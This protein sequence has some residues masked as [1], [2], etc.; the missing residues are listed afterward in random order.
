[1]PDYSLSIDVILFYSFISLRIG[2]SLLDFSNFGLC[3]IFLTL[4]FR[5]IFNLKIFLFGGDFTRH[6]I[7]IKGPI[8]F[9]LVVKGI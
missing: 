5:G 3:V 9:V 8:Q 2:V 6:V 1:M 4:F 7:A